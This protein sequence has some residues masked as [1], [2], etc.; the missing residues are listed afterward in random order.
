MFSAQ[1]FF[2][3]D[4][5]RYSKINKLDSSKIISG[6]L[7]SLSPKARERYLCDE[8]LAK[9]KTI[10]TLSEK[11]SLPPAAIVCAALASIREC[12]VFPII[13][14]KSEVQIKESLSGGDIVLSVAEVSSLFEFI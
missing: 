1:L 4:Y 9:V 2:L 8:N 11:Y 12:D 5:M 13:G 7:D 14:G 3:G 6:G 10:S